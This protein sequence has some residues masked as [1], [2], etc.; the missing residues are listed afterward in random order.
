MNLILFTLAFAIAV[1]LVWKLWK[2]FVMPPKRDLAPNEARILFIY[3]N[4]CG[5]S[6]KAMPEWEALESQL[7]KIADFGA[8]RV[9]PVSID[10][11][12]DRAT[13]TLYEVEGYPTVLLETHEGIFPYTKR[14]TASGVRE[15]LRSK[16]GEER[17]SL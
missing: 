15:F 17:T 1:V 10:A 9:T 8:T 4:W 16:L 6:K 13:A 3:T 11:E 12:A 14:V 5:H 2:P 7:D